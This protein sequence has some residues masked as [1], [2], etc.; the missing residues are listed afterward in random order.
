[1]VE[2]EA[3]N[4]AELICMQLRRELYPTGLNPK[5]LP[6]RLASYK[7]QGLEVL[8]RFTL[9]CLEELGL[10][11]TVVDPLPTRKELLAKKAAERAAQRELELVD[12]VRHLSAMGSQRYGY[13]SPD[14]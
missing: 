4:E 7:L 6:P 13:I 8:E 9:Q 14:F 11:K 1:M 10:C 2:L 5:A 3:L 12:S